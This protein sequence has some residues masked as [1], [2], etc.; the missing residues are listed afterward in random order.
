M[1]KSFNV[2]QNGNLNNSDDTLKSESNK[3][4]KYLT[5]LSEKTEALNDCGIDSA[6]SPSGNYPRS[7]V[8]KIIEEFRALRKNNSCDPNP[9]NPCVLDD[10]GLVVPDATPEVNIRSDKIVPVGNDEITITCKEAYDDYFSQADTKYYGFL[11]NSVTIGKGTFITT[12]RN[13]TSSRQESTQL[14]MNILAKELALSQ[15]VCGYENNPYELECPSEAQSEED[16]TVIDLEPLTIGSRTSTI[17]QGDITVNFNSDDLEV[18]AQGNIR[19]ANNNFNSYDKSLKSQLFARAISGLSCT[20]GNERYEVSCGSLPDS[21]NQGNLVQNVLGDPQ[22]MPI[23]SF[24]KNLST[25]YG[26]F[27]VSQNWD[28][29]SYGDTSKIET[30]LKELAYDLVTSVNEQAETALQSASTCNY[31]NTALS[32]SCP[33]GYEPMIDDDINSTIDSNIFVISENTSDMIPPPS[34]VS[35]GEHSY[36]LNFELSNSSARTIYN[37]IYEQI[38]QRKS[39]YTSYNCG[40]YNNTINL[41]CDKLTAQTAAENSGDVIIFRDTENIGDTTNYF[42]FY[43]TNNANNLIIAKAVN[44]D[45][46]ESQLKLAMSVQDYLS[47]TGLQYRKSFYPDGVFLWEHDYPQDQKVKGPTEDVSVTYDPWQCYP[48]GIANY[49]T[50][51]G[52]NSYSSSACVHNADSPISAKYNFTSSSDQCSITSVESEGYP[53]NSQQNTGGYSQITERLA[54]ESVGIVS[55]SVAAKSFIEL[56]QDT[57]DEGSVMTPSDIQGLVNEQALAQARS[58]I[59]CMYG[60]ITIYEEDC[61]VK[62]GSCVPFSNNINPPEILANTYFADTPTNADRQAVIAHNAMAVC[63]CADWMGGGGGSSLSITLDGDCSS[64]CEHQYCVFIPDN[65]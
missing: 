55:A 60:N 32:I 26:D 7:K 31:G 29:K 11:N 17:P 57:I 65:L 63:M 43:I 61:S 39:A 5:T 49:P 13:P 28:L 10:T 18:T 35:S 51:E 21:I 27:F 38:D 22:I 59:S 20:Y 53:F 52:A 4:L 2:N 62:I 1:A 41:Y 12:L 3:H 14:E 50:G 16:Q 36:I 6:I 15:I 44:T 8:K 47:D 30:K 46:P 19:T 33:M 23:G 48:M 42:R 45:V 54:D 34:P 64:E 58:S 37:N 24:V 40:I 25:F 9:Y 56:Y